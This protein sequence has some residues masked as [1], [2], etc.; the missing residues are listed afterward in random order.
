MVLNS[1]KAKIR[2]LKEQLESG[3][4]GG[5]GSSSGGKSA[6]STIN[7]QKRPTIVES[8]EEE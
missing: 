1:K 6:K 5:A 3:R 4:D 2:E 8:D 7:E